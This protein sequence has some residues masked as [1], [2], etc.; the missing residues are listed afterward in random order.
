MDT[1]LTTAAV[2]ADPAWYMLVF[3][4]F[5]L[6]WWVW[7]G[8]ASI[9]VIYALERERYWG[10]G[11]LFLAT[12]AAMWVFGGVNVL[13]WIVAN[14]WMA[15]AIFGGYFLIGAVF[16]LIKWVLFVTGRRHDYEDL[17]VAWLRSIDQG[18]TA[19]PAN[20]RG[21]WEKHLLDTTE[22]D[23]RYDRKKW[24]VQL[25]RKKKV[26][27][28]PIAWEHKSRITAWITVW[29]WSAFWTIFDDIIIRIGEAIQ[30]A[31]AKVMDA[32]ARKAFSGTDED[33]DK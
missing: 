1:M 2:A 15:L 4:P 14:P 16:S 32:I 26:R 3:V 30:T 7:I 25:G 12:F 28:V 18:G 11:A 8:I 17:K 22:H 33:F 21:D 20:M 6:L 31:L 29:P 23:G 10:M 13:A 27:I 5:T 24:W 9:Y 19:I